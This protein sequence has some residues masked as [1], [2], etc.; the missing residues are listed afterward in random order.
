MLA[1]FAWIFFRARSLTDALYIV[2]NIFKADTLR[3]LNLFKFPVDFYLSFALI[4]ILF[5]ID[6]L[7]DKMNISNWVPR[8]PVI[9]R[10]AIYLAPIIAM[11]VLGVWRS[12][13][14]IY[15]QF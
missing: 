15:F 11:F 13:D 8:S 12:A 3:N 14:F 5:L 7:D 1:S 4:L 9:I 2:E 10:W 6:W